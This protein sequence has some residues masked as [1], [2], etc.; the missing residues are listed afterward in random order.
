[1]RIQLIWPIL[2]HQ[3][4]TSIGLG[5]ISASSKARGHDVKLIQL[6]QDLGYPLDLDRI[7]ED[8]RAYAPGLIGFSIVTNQYPTARKIAAMLKATPD[9]AAIPILMG[10]PHCT[11]FPEDVMANPD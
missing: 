3:A 5:F 6:S 10:G 2:D 9:L 1:M 7:R 8:V 4:V 11:I